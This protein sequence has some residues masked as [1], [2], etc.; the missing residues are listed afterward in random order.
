[1][2]FT[3]IAKPTL[4]Q[5]LISPRE[6][7]F[8]LEYSQRFNCS[9]WHGTP[10]SHLN[11][12]A[13]TAWFKFRKCTLFSIR[14]AI[15]S[16]ADL[17]IRNS[18]G[19]QFKEIAAEGQDLCP[20]GHDSKFRRKIRLWEDSTRGWGSGEE[21]GVWTEGEDNLHLKKKKTIV[22][23][24][25]WDG[26]S[27]NGFSRCQRCSKERWPCSLLWGSSFL[28]GDA[29]RFPFAVNSIPLQS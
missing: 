15:S 20:R 25:L 4:D 23:N 21:W 12:R 28:K 7:N 10:G 14:S 29:N 5:F 24:V 1:M 18:A 11:Q 8:K 17:Y 6:C 22:L 3:R 9:A 26:V 2:L 16:P 19:D 13:E 27:V